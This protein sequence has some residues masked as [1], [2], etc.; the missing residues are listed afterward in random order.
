MNPPFSLPSSSAFSHSSLPEQFFEPICVFFPRSPFEPL[1]H[2]PTFPSHW[3]K[4]CQ[5]YILGACKNHLLNFSPQEVHIV[6]IL[7]LLAWPQYFPN[8]YA[9]LAYSRYLLPIPTLTMS[10]CSHI[11]LVSCKRGKHKLSSS[12]YLQFYNFPT[13]SIYVTCTLSVF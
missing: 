7:A 2:V 1:I 8:L 11:C 10:Y 12:L 3:C 4:G 6:S 5:C 9:S 13:L